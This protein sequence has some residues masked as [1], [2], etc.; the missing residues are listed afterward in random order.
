[1]L[2]PPPDKVLTSRAAA[3]AVALGRATALGALLET[4]RQ[5]IALAGSPV[6]LEAGEFLVQA[7]DIGDAIYVVVEGEI[8]VSGRSE[9]GR[10]VRLASMTRG[11]VV[12]EMAALDGGVRSADMVAVRRC[13]LWRI[14][15]TAILDALRVEPDAAL[16]LI[17]ELSRRLRATNDLIESSA[18]LDLGGRV[19]KLLLGAAGPSGCSCAHPDRDRP[20]NRR[21]AR[22]GEPQAARLVSRR[23][24]GAD[25]TGSPAAPD[26]LP[27]RVDRVV[28]A[29]M[30]LSGPRAPA[31]LARR[32][33]R[34]QPL[35][36]PRSAAARTV[37]RR[38]HAGKSAPW[39]SIGRSPAQRSWAVTLIRNARRW[40]PESVAMSR[41]AKCT[42]RTTT[43]APSSVCAWT[44]LPMHK[45]KANAGA[46]AMAVG[47]N[48][49]GLLEVNLAFAMSGG[50]SW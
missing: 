20:A 27:A 12:G 3:I 39:R 44:T 42:L 45:A 22:E 33:A 37:D 17:A 31:L 2:A 49:I 21:F 25:A 26:R 11:A 6:T 30:R 34:P 19:A 8:E 10:Q 40:A 50:W 28:A 15:R 24:G 36:E 16:A 41:S 23:L 47:R 9:G 29:A 18:F 14:P 13:Q 48:M 7:G 32:R 43:C 38:T 1:M 4:T 35:D 46:S 5:R